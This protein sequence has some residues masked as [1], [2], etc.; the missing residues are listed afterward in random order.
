ML[1]VDTG[2]ESLLMVGSCL[3]TMAS[4]LSTILDSH[5]FSPTSLFTIETLAHDMLLE[6][7]KH[8]AFSVLPNVVFLAAILEQSEQGG[9][10]GDGK[11]DHMDRRNGRGKNGQQ[12]KKKQPGQYK[13]DKQGCMETNIVRK[14]ERILVKNSGLYQAL[15]VEL[16]EV[17]RGEKHPTIWMSEIGCFIINNNKKPLLNDQWICTV[18]TSIIA[19]VSC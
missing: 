8:T 19:V 6:K 13:P 12:I 11:D 14:Q 17:G 15:D 10:M 3:S 1:K 5:L 9:I 7:H 16:D 18:S 2:G 4:R